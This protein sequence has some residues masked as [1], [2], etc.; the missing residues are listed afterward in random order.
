M[1]GWEFLREIDRPEMISSK[2]L[3]ER[4]T[5]DKRTDPA[6]VSRVQWQTCPAKRPLSEA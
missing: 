5:A 1:R 4:L 2:S 3:Q 6:L